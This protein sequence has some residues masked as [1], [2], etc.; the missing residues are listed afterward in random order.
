MAPPIKAY[1]IEHGWAQL[2]LGTFVEKGEKLLLQVALWPLHACV[3]THMDTHTHM[4]AKKISAIKMFKCYWKVVSMLK[5]ISSK[6][7]K[8]ERELIYHGQSQ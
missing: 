7:K 5:K 1:T 3:Y 6:K 8:K 2:I 4:Q